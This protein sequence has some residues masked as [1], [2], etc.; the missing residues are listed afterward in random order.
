[1]ADVTETAVIKQDDPFYSDR[2]YLD[3]QFLR[4]AGLQHLGELSGQIWS[5]HNT[6]DPGVTILEALCYALMDL[7]YR[8]TLPV[9]DLRA[10]ASGVSSPAGAFAGDDNF[11]TP[12]EILSCNPTTVADYRKLLLEVDGVRNAW[13]EPSKGDDPAL[14]LAGGPGGEPG[15]NH[16]LA[17]GSPSP[18]ARRIPLNGLYSVLI[19][20]DPAAD[21]RVIFTGVQK[22]LSAHR[23]LCE[24]FREVVVL[25][26][27]EIGICAD[28]EIEKAA[29]PTLV[30]EAVLNAIQSYISPRIHYYTLKQLLDKGKA[31]EEIYAGRPFLDKSVGFIDLEEL[32]NLPLRKELYASDLYR[33]IKEIDGVVAIRDLLF[34]TDGAA[35]QGGGNIQRVRIPNRYVA[36]FSLEHT[37]IQLRVGPSV[38]HFDKRRIHT[39]LA[40]S[41]KASLERQDLDIQI[42]E[43][44]FDPARPDYNSVQNDFPRVY[45]LGE[46]GL[47]ADTTLLRQVQAQQ[48][49]GYLLFYDQLL[50]NYLAQI[51]NFRSLFSRQQESTRSPLERHTYFNHG[52]ERVPGLKQL[53]QLSA[54]GDPSDGS[55]LAVPV[56]NNDTVKRTLKELDPRQELRIEG[57]CGPEE[58]ALPHLA[59]GTDT[60]REISVRQS[61]RDLAQGDYGIEIYEDQG[62]QFFI[63]RF[64]QV[65]TWLFVGYLRYSK[66]A[67][68]R[69][70]ANY[71]AF[72]ATRP[73]YYRKTTQQNGEG[74]IDYRFD[75]V[76]NLAAN[77]TYLQYL[78][79]NQELYRERREAFLDHLLARFGNQFTDYAL[80]QYQTAE[81]KRQD[82]TQAIEDKSRF[83]S[84][85]DELSRNRGRAFDYREPSWGTGNVSGYEMRVSLLAGIPTWTRRRLGKFEV[86]ES[87]RITMNDPSGKL[88]FSS[89]ADY[90]SKPEVEKSLK[91]LK[92]ELRNPAK[93]GEL[94]GRFVGFVTEAVRRIFSEI[95]RDENIQASP[96]VH[97]LQLKDSTGN[98]RQQSRK[99]DYAQESQAWG[100]LSTFLEEIKETAGLGL[101]LEET[102]EKSRMY[103]DK[104]RFHREIQAVT[105][106]APQY[107]WRFIRVAD[108]EPVR[109]CSQDFP[110]EDEAARDFEETIRRIGAEEPDS[111]IGRQ[112]YTIGLLGIPPRYRFVYCVNSAEGRGLPLLRSQQEFESREAAGQAYAEFIH[113]LPRL[114][115]T[116]SAISDDTRAIAVLIEDS[117]EGRRRADELLAYFHQQYGEAGE[118]PGLQPK[119]IYRLIDRDH[120]IASTIACH[121]TKDAAQE[122]L[123]GVCG[124]KPY[125]IRCEDQLIRVI[126]PPLDPERFHYAIC[127]Q[128]EAGEDSIFLISDLGYESREAAQEAGEANGIKL[129]ELATESGNY[130]AGKGI[131]LEE[132]YGT[133]TDDCAE[134]TPY[135]VVLAK[136]YWNRVD[137]AVELAKR[138]PIRIAH[139]KDEHDQ[140][141]TEVE[142]YYFQGYDLQLKT[143]IWQSAKVY[144][145]VS[146]AL[147]EYQVFVV[148]LGNPDSC[149]VV[150]E[151]RRMR[152]ANEVLE[153]RYCLHLVEILAESGEFETEDDAWGEPQRTAVD[154]CGRRVCRNRGVRL[155]AEAAITDTAFIP[156]HESGCFHFAVVG[157]GYVVARHTCT[158]SS[159]EKRDLARKQVHDLAS[160]FNA[161]TY[162]RELV[163][164]SL[165]YY[166]GAGYYFESIRP[167]SDWKEAEMVQIVD[168]WF[169]LAGRFL[170]YQQNGNEWQLCD[171]LQGRTDQRES[172]GAGEGSE[173]KD[174]P[175]AY[176]RR[177]T[178]ADGFDIGTFKRLARKYPV[179]KKGDRYH[180]RLYYS[181]NGGVLD[182]E[183]TRCG[184]KE[185]EP[186]GREAKPF[187]GNPHL[188]VSADG[189]ACRAAA[190]EAFIR[191]CDLVKVPANYRDD[192]ESGLG[193]Y[194]FSI[195][196]PTKVLAKHPHCHADAADAM[197]ALERA[198]ACIRDE[199]MHLVEHILLRP[200]AC[201]Q[202][203]GCECLLPV[204]PDFACELT[205]EDDLDEDDPCAAT[206]TPPL[207]CIPGA[208]PYSFWATLVL[209]GWY[210]R[211]QSKE[212]RQFFKEMLHRE[213]PAMVGLN[214]LWLSPRQMC[215]F[216]EAFRSWLDWLRDP[217]LLCEDTDQALCNLV[218]CLKQ[219]R[220]DAPCPIP[221]TASAECDCLP[222]VKE[223]PCRCIN[224][225]EQ[226][227]WLECEPKEQ[228][229]DQEN[230]GIAQPDTPAATA[231][232]ITA[233]PVAT[234][235]SVGVDPSAIRQAIAKRE[236]T[237]RENIRAV[238]SEQIRATT[239]YQQAEF[240]VNNPPGIDAFRRLAMQILERDMGRRR[241]KTYDSFKS[242]LQNATWYLLDKLVQTSPHEVPE[243]VRAAL[244]V[245]L[246]AM[247]T[248]GMDPSRMAR[249]WKSKSLERVLDASAIQQYLKLFKD[250]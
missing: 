10:R 178:A 247:K 171:P 64:T 111:E 211:F 158:Y 71:A 51:A 47:P 220:N 148:V 38:L 201:R 125:R 119:W 31:I 83:L 127:L 194:T 208:D 104:R 143:T 207:Q 2:P 69:A 8:T 214:I 35:S 65:S 239:G 24:D 204:C 18:N 235:E 22:L 240:F 198:R 221:K 144:A 92:E 70:A 123:Q 34:Q 218:D 63:L 29:E 190:E 154:A 52:L 217:K 4:R 138:Y 202:N 61:M 131:A 117:E 179:F 72:L 196:D 9:E 68:A 152:P 50:A 163:N 232:E 134:T 101:E 250:G 115:R 192:A 197:R 79:E 156:Q 223:E 200:Q 80:L 174:A 182:E 159:A 136:D 106:N 230:E 14:Y 46:G 130:G 199:G 25:C 145:T 222:K 150:C 97:A 126:C 206:E 60:L 228:P 121:E 132:T 87:Y 56:K 5:D 213:A 21:D 135:R 45:G 23:N 107:R 54:G 226:L 57:S 209:P 84:H 164:G 94:E 167:F 39:R 114:R 113:A 81:T 122:S 153:G 108:G 215:E 203:A 129:I 205:W 110:S 155:F 237:Y 186:D 142:G 44:R 15:T 55:V 90:H 12:L 183:L 219:L 166:I 241:T 28:V 62:G 20:K 77:S 95:P 40:V 76:S 124:F 105:E 118:R 229:T 109:E 161:D 86:V 170:N 128:N 187:C 49:Q 245:L 66:P 1:M 58:G 168:R 210:P 96:F 17:C 78:L 162:S 99:K 189:H 19:E 103:F 91:E 67:D 169:Y 30:Y 246:A 26:P 188:F 248:R 227:F 93:Y 48:L 116:E 244:P 89:K 59:H 185:S 27:F 243:E 43:G 73:E 212:K 193:P 177:E 149:R 82:R 225:P 233:A 85:Y 234:R 173:E 172:G 180:F 147:E 140:P 184:C 42:P 242:I 6:H 100:D 120:P 13:L 176:V 175:V 160:S 157:E 236:A 146:E 224:Q 133:G 216:D 165:R 3:F 249:D 231:A 37:C 139:K 36:S 74:S 75:L 112:V 141:T 16:T 191:F 11:F 33:S 238:S 88:W 7:G 41:G 53:L 32:Q 195:I 98:V 151:P 102:R 181:E 137:D